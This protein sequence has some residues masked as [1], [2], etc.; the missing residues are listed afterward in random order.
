MLCLNEKDILKAVSLHD[1]LEA[2][3]SALLLYE[4]KEF[5]MP[6]RTHVEYQGN[7][8]LL[9]PA[10]MPGVFGTKLVSV[11]PGNVEKNIPVLKGTMILNDGESGEPLALLDAAALTAL[12]TGAVGAAGVKYLSPGNAGSLGIV[13]AGVQGF[14]QAWFA[15]E[16]RDF[17]EVF[18]YDTDSSRARALVRKLSAKRTGITIRAAS[19]IDELVKN[20]RVIITATASME[21]VLPNNKDLMKGKHV[22]AIG[23]YK[24]TM[25]ELPEVLF[26]LLEHL[27]VDTGHAVEES[28][29]LV[30]PLE[31]RWIEK[32]RVSTL[33][34]LITRTKQGKYTPHETTLFKSVGMAL[35]DVVVS[36][37]IYRKAVEK[38]L[39]QRVII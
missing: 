24:P 19:T 36:N 38:K 32:E 8:L 34:T 31:N 26:R 5:H 4:E 11:F 20:S 25:R 3:E 2:V 30:I 17:K 28:G 35:F 39:G 6:L 12:R 9:M 27:Y 10:F 22:V 1:V 14:H 33:G 16:V 21:P 18:V 15:T 13:G 7:T 23:S 37:A 29:D